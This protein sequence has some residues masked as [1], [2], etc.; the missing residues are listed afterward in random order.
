MKKFIF[1]LQFIFPILNL[2]AGLLA[3]A[4]ED[5]ISPWTNA[6]AQK[7]LIIGTSLTLVAVFQKD[8]IS[9]DLREDKPLCCNLTKP[10][11]V[12]M[13]ILPNAVYSL[14]MGLNFYLFKKDDDSKRRAIGMAKATLYSGLLADIIKPIVNEKRPNGG[15]SS[16]PSGHTTTAFAFAAFVASEHSLSFGLPAY[17]MATYVGICRMQDHYHY[18]LDVLAGATIGISY[19]IALAQNSKS[20][21]SGPSAFIVT[22][23]EELKGLS[24]K[25]ALQ[26]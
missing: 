3:D 25:Y 18:F 21:G 17:A 11:N 16:F 6:T 9:K 14:A 12:F 24:F 8:M 5:V 10:G 2:H 4:K 20:G 13:Q 26:F 22:P 1:I 7:V 19:G 23:T 15:N